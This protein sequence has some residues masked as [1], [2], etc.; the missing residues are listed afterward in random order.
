M[1][2]ARLT[3]LY[4]Y[5]FRATTR[6]SESATC[7]RPANARYRCRSRRPSP[8]TH[9]FS[10]SARAGQAVFERHGTAVEPLPVAPDVVNL[11]GPDKPAASQPTNPLPK[12]TKTKEVKAKGGS[13]EESR[14]PDAAIPEAASA[15]PNN[16]T[17][18]ATPDSSIDGGKDTTSAAPHQAA[19][20]E[21]M[22]QSGPM[23]A[24]LHMPPP[25]NSHHPHISK[26]TYVHHFDSYTLVKQLQGSG[27]TQDQAITAMKAV[28]TILAQ[29]LDF[30]QEGLVGKSDVDNVGHAKCIV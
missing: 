12:E 10:T 30:A 27:Y 22:H 1:S 3:F 19:V 13:A 5:L 23:E 24:V 6:R 9:S 4:P 17:K 7:P 11:P 26:P 15:P 21:K 18:D 29:N 28:R 16:T 8:Y 25:N 14:E 2:T 20:N